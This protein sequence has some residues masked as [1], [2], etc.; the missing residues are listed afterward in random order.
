MK[1]LIIYMKEIMFEILSS[2]YIL[3]MGGGGGGRKNMEKKEKI[4]SPIRNDKKVR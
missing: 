4:S 3:S 1:K 2:G